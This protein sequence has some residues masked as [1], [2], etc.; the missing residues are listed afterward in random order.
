MEEGRTFLL[1]YIHDCTNGGCAL[2]FAMDLEMLRQAKA[3]SPV[4]ILQFMAPV[5][6]CS[7]VLAVRL[8][9]ASRF[10]QNQFKLKNGNAN[11][12][13]QPIDTRH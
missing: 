9:H 3:L 11:L 13:N 8:W 1:S 10:R 12:R 6:I 7:H 4:A 2:V 5:E